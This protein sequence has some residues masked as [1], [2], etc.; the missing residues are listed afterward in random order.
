MQAVIAWLLAVAALAGGYLSYGWPGVVLAVT[1]I[2]FWLLLQFNRT[3]RVM[4][5][6]GERPVGT[7]DN[8]VMLH[9]RLRVGMPLLSIVGMTRSLGRLVEDAGTPQDAPGSETYEWRDGAGDRVVVHCAR[10]RCSRWQLLRHA[11]PAA[12]MADPAVD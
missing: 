5:R 10:G 8:A 3:L 11:G 9:A 12:S 1:C 4:R 7:V 2:V 6:A